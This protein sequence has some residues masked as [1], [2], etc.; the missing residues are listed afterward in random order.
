MLDLLKLITSDLLY[1]LIV[2][3]FFLGTGLILVAQ[4]IPDLFKQYK[5]PAQLSGIFLI[6]FFTFQSGKY[7]EYTNWKVQELELNAKIQ[8]LNAQSKEIS[9]KTITEYIDRIQYVDRWKEIQIDKFIP[10]VSNKACVIDS[11]TG[12]NIRLLINES[13]KGGT[14]PSTSFTNATTSTTNPVK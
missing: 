13:H 11:V 8:S 2:P 6:L 12:S 14:I 1:T 7:T 10:D 9:I 5:L 3:G 4:F